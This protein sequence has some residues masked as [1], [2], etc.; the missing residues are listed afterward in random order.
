MVGESRDKKTGSMG[1]E[2]SLTGRMVFSA[3]P[4]NLAPESIT[5][6]LDMGMYSFNFVDLLL[7]IL[8][9]RLAKKLCDCEESCVPSLQ[10]LKDGIKKYAEELRHADAWKIEVGVESQKPAQ[11]L[12]R[13]LFCR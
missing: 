10:Q 9:P 8:A 2:A 11:R 12:D 5:R 4:T 13:T 6:L 1:V 3:L 7:D